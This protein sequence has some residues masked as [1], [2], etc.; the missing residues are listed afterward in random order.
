MVGHVITGVSNCWVCYDDERTLI[1]RH[2]DLVEGI[3]LHWTPEPTTSTPVA[4]SASIGGSEKPETVV[5]AA[6]VPA[7]DAEPAPCPPESLDELPW[8]DRG[9]P[10]RKGMEY[11]LGLKEGQ[12]EASSQACE[13]ATRED[14]YTLLPDYGLRAMIVPCDRDELSGS[15]WVQLTPKAGTRVGFEE[16]I[17]VGDT[18]WG[19]CRVYMYPAALHVV[20]DLE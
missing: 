17:R 15:T 9:S 11:A 20:F 7:P 2:S 19:R 14:V 10:M 4:S 5:L 16:E 6:A 8:I 3:C 12:P 18:P 13:L 1:N